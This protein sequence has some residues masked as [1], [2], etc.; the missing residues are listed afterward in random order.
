MRQ[1]IGWTRCTRR[2]AQTAAI[3]LLVTLA[4]TPSPAAAQVV[5]LPELVGSAGQ[6]IKVSMASAEYDAAFA[7]WERSRSEQGWK[8]AIGAG[9]GQQRDL[10]DESRSRDFEAIRTDVKL[11]YPLL[12][13]SAKLER[14]IETASGKVA[15]ARI[16]RD[17]AL[18][19]AQLQIEDVYAALWGAQESLEVI[20]A[21][22]SATRDHDSAGDSEARKDQRRLAR[23]R[24]DA[25]ARLEQLT[26]RE[27]KGLI[28]TGVQLPRMPELDPRR[29]QQDHP[30]LAALRAQHA[31]ARAQLDGSVWYGIDAGF[32]L[33][34]STIQDRDGG[35]A[36]NALFANFT[37]VLPVTFY[38]AG[39]AE[40]S[41]L[42]AEMRFLELKLQDMS[43]EIVGRAQGTEAEYLDLADEV[44]G[45]TRKTRTAAEGL[46]NAGSGA[47]SAALR[48]YYQR[49]LAEIDARTRY[50]RSHVAMRS[51][52]PVGAAEP[53]PETP[54]PTVSDVGTRLAE[55]LLRVAGR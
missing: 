31:S 21:Y 17:A 46:R 13:A 2:N 55:P 26:G 43:D 22:R 24:D 3:A 44:D 15:E 10:I 50:W 41:K 12:G 54:G 8:L 39:L 47:G 42:R 1:S 29:L 52:V 38:Q 11:A 36:G 19:M 30:E 9:Y 14:D 25:R 23:R 53:A 4:G 37:V 27:L 40:R 18:K 51:F 5:S 28:V 6:S 32:D 34:Q 33:T 7:D 49:A 48:E 16:G 35:Q 45:A 20:A